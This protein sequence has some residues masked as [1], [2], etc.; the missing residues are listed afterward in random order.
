ML[1]LLLEGA[2]A[3]QKLIKNI[4][5]ST[6]RPEGEPTRQ[7]PEPDKYQNYIAVDTSILR[8]INT[9][10]LAS[11][12]VFTGC[13]ASLYSLLHGSRLVELVGR[14]GKRTSKAKWRA[15]LRSCW[16]QEFQFPMIR[17]AVRQTP[18]GGCGVPFLLEV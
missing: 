4:G 5:N 10:F 9:P 12:G 14:S 13:R 6:A 1:F 16:E 18:L 11:F 3:E 17:Q 7:K 2:P 8:I 15:A